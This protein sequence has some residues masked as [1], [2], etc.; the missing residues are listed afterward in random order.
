M[1]SIMPMA[2]AILKQLALADFRAERE[3]NENMELTPSRREKV[4][5]RSLSADFGKARENIV[6][7]PFFPI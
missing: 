7:S 6:F 3:R 1:P 4:Y 5:L 2:T